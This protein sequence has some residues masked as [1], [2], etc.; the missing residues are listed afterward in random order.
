MSGFIHSP[1]NQQKGFTLI[2]LIV[3]I[4]VIG[5]GLAG[6]TIAIHQATQGSTNPLFKQQAN[7]IAQSYLEEVMLKSF[8]DPDDFASTGALCMANCTSPACGAGCGTVQE[9]SRDL[10]DNVCDYD[11]LSDS[12]AVDQSGAAVTGL[13]SY[14]VSVSVV[15]DAA[16]NFGGLSATAGEVVRIDV[17]VQHSNGASSALSGYR[18]NY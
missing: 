5:V 16:A 7:A 17:N 12:G 9:A 13:G 3:I 1:R 11:G 8:C 15:D 18:A 14:N 10:Y 6:L 2:E 4:V